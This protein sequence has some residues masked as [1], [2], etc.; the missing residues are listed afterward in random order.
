[1]NVRYRMTSARAVALMLGVL[2]A[3]VV[4]LSALLLTRGGDPASDGAPLA[5]GSSASPSTTAAETST[6]GPS[7]TPDATPTA[8]AT[9]PTATP[10]PTAAPAPTQA[11]PQEGAR[12]PIDS[13]VRIVTDDLR[14]R[15]KPG[16]GDDSVKL[17]PLLW[18]GSAAFVLDGPVAASGYEWY[19]IEPLGEVDIQIH[20]DP[21]RLG[22]V[23]AAGRDGEPWLEQVDFDCEPNPLRSLDYD[24]DYP[25]SRFLAL[26][27]NGDTPVEFTA[28]MSAPVDQCGGPGPWVAE[29]SWLDPC[30]GPRH[31]LIDVLPHDY[32]DDRALA[33]SVDPAVDL[34]VLADLDV[35]EYL[36]VDVIG[37]YDHPAASGCRAEASGPSDEPKPPPELVIRDCRARFVVTSIRVHIDQ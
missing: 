13:L 28:G 9:A 27:C 15:S 21:P 35:G 8:T 12:F 7:V 36:V 29:P 23:A 5:A 4:G 33:I 14:V 2:L 6:S 25:P 3:V 26:A 17:E 10:E 24:F 20:P 11:P 32:E 19:L 30:A 37:Q 31:T 34:D 16:V 18:N 22:W 1:M